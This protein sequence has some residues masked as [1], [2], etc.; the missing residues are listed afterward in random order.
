[1]RSHQQQDAE[2]GE[3]SNDGQGH[4]DEGRHGRI[5][6][7][8]QRPDS[9]GGE[10]VDHGEPRQHGFRWAAEVGGLYDPHSGDRTEDQSCDQ[11]PVHR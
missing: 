11:E 2:Y 8:Q 6:T 7:E 9:H 4:Q 5:L 10:R 1:M 3:R